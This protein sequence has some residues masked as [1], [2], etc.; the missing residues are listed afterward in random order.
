MQK[1]SHSTD[2]YQLTA[3]FLKSINNIKRI[4]WM[5]E[6]IRIQPTARY[7]LKGNNLMKQ[8]FLQS[9]FSGTETLKL[10]EKRKL[11]LKGNSLEIPKNYNSKELFTIWH[12]CFFNWK[13][14][15]PLPLFQLDND[16][17]RQYRG[18]WG[19]KTTTMTCVFTDIL[20]NVPIF[21]ICKNP[22]WFYTK[23]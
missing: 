18:W 11:V 2:F 5:S 20:W 9:G 23:N 1:S 6:N 16:F 22:W 14:T 3:F 13:R 15:P 7:P 19:D 12:L 17:Q 21:K 10:M 8:V 4:F